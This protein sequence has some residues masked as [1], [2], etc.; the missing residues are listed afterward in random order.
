MQSSDERRLLE[1]RMTGTGGMSPKQDVRSGLMFHQADVR[2]PLHQGDNLDRR[3]NYDEQLCR[4]PL[5]H[6]V[7]IVQLIRWEKAVDCASSGKKHEI[8][9][10]WPSGHA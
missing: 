9:S 10:I 7:V 3:S 1:H 5:F 2:E 6:D 4:S 8:F